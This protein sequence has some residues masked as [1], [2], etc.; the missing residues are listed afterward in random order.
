MMESVRRRGG[1]LD[2]F[3]ESEIKPS[4]QHEM[5]R[6]HADRAD[7]R[8]RA[9]LELLLKSLQS[10]DGVP[11]LLFGDLLQLAPDHRGNCSEALQFILIHGCPSGFG[12][13]VESIVG[14]MEKQSVAFEEMTCAMDWR[15][16]LSTKG[17]RSDV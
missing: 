12:E 3:V 9:V 7:I 10:G 5:D 6:L 4:F 13:K 17:S 1:V 2:C 15:L 16:K 11:A 14:Q 8:V